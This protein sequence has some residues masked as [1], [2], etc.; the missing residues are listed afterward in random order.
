MASSDT[1]VRAGRAALVALLGWWTLG[2]VLGHSTWRLIDWANLPFHE[3]GHVFLSPFGRT[4]HLLGGTL[5]QLLIPVVLGVS[6]V[7]KQ[8]SPFGGAFCTWWLGENLTNVALYMADARELRLDLVGG[9]VHDWNELFYRFGLLSERAVAT[10]SGAT[11][12]LGILFL[13]IGLAWAIFFLLPGQT[14]SRLGEPVRE[15]LPWASLL[16]GE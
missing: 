13:L 14:R 15:R 11:R 8:T 2:I 3:A 16:L 5:F 10:V 1:L 6:L 12:G 4:A 9:G 7:L